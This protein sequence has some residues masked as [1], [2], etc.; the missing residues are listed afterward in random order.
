MKLKNIKIVVFMLVII[1]SFSSCSLYKLYKAANKTKDTGNE[2]DIEID[3]NI[4]GL[5]SVEEVY[6]QVYNET[7]RQFEKSRE[8]IGMDT[9]DDK[10]M[11]EFNA[12]IDTRRVYPAIAYLENKY[13]KK[14]YFLTYW[15]ATL[16]DN[17]EFII[18]YPSDKLSSELTVRVD[19]EKNDD[20]GEFEYE[21]GY[22][23]IILQDMYNDYL[24][25]GLESLNTKAQIR[26]AATIYEV[27]DKSLVELPEKVE[28]LDGKLIV[29][30][31]VIVS[32]EKATYEEYKKLIEDFKKWSIEHKIAGDTGFLYLRGS[33]ADDY[34]IEVDHYFTWRES[35]RLLSEDEIEVREEDF[36]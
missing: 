18:V 2:L 35:E 6:K 30:N 17:E 11:I 16:L 15:P 28:D 34:E 9:K 7:K 19:I 21:D 12:R 14:F 29:D 25:K 5:S 31:Y 33:I 24:R 22:M 32:N 4:K 36:K 23:N 27:I 1:L 20:N 13:N 8:E 3:P 10:G 26:T